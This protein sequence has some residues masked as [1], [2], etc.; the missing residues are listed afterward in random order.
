MNNPPNNFENL[1]DN[2]D[3]PAIHKIK[4]PSPEMIVSALIQLVGHNPQW[5]RDQTLRMMVANGV[6][7]ITEHIAGFVNR[8]EKPD[9]DI[10][11][12]CFC[13]ILAERLDSSRRFASQEEKD[14]YPPS[15]L[16]QD[17]ED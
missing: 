8:G 1:F 13:M 14:L 2:E 12:G 7:C 9:M 15:D 3:H 17:N 5:Y 10:L 6:A 11:V 4:R 16:K